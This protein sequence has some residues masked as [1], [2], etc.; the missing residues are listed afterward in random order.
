MNLGQGFPN[1]P[2]PAYVKDAAAAAV[3]VDPLNQYAPATGLPRLRQALGAAFSPLFGRTLD[4]NAE[5][6]VCQGATEGTVAAF[7]AIVDAG[8]EVIL[9][10]VRGVQ[11]GACAH[12]P[13][14]TGA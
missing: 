7:Q 10:E 9:L 3:H 13:C 6:L 2:A 11:F 14:G 8:D 1:F 5:I 12:T 4:P